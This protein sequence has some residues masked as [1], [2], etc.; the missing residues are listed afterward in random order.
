MRVQTV[1]AKS[2]HKLVAS[3]GVFNAL[4]LGVSGWLTWHGAPGIA[5]RLWA[6]SLVLLMAS[7]FVWQ[8]GSRRAAL[9][10][11]E[12][13]SASIG[14]NPRHDPALTDG[15]IGKADSRIPNL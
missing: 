2:R 10:S 11:R 4:L 6:I 13:L 3:I 8:L 15:G 14:R 12:L 9:L 1:L 7:A 5:V